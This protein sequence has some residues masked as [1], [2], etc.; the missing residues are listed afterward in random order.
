MLRAISGFAVR[1]PVLVVVLW[2]V[3]TA[4][5]FGFGVGV[6][7]RLVG[8]VDTVAGSESARATRLLEGAGDR[9]ESIAALFTGRPA[10]DPALRA[11]VDRAVAEVR[12][13]T[14]VVQVDGPLPSTATGHALLL[15]ITLE[16]DRLAG[17]GE[18]V[19]ASDVAAAVAARLHRI[20]ATVPAA[21]VVVGGGPLQAHETTAQAQKD[22]IKAELLTT[23]VVLVLLLLVFAGLIAA[24]LPLLVAVAGVGATF[25][26]LYLCSMVTDVSLYAIQTTTTLAV[27]LA[28]DYALLMVSR[29]REERRRAPDLSTAVLATATTAGR[30]VVCSGL[31]VA[32]ALAGLVVFPNPF[33]RSMGLAGATVV[34]VDA[35]AVVTLLPALLALT[36][37]HITTVRP[38]PDRGVFAA[39]ARLVQ[40]RPVIVL[41]TTAALLTLLAVPALG[42]RISQGDPRM[43]PPGSQTRQL[44]EGLATHFP[45]RVRPDGV[46]LVATATAT[47]PALLRLRDRIAALPGVSGVAVVPVSPTATV[48]DI[49]GTAD[50]VGTVR[51]V[52]APFEIAVGGSAA[53]LAD[54]RTMLTDRLPWAIAI[55]LAGTLLLLFAL[56]GSAVLPVKAV[57]TN[58]L[59]LAAALGVVVWVFQNGH[60][61]AVLDDQGLGYVHLT[62]PVLAGAIAFGLA[63]DYEVF[64]LARIRE[65]WLTDAEPHTCVAHG[66]QRTGGI[67]T[68]AALILGVVFGG[69]LVGG[70]TPIKAVGLGLLVAVVLDAT[71]VRMLLVPATMT[72]LGR[73][74]WWLPG[75][76]HTLHRRIAITET[77][78]T[79]PPA[80][81][82][83]TAGQ[84]A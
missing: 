24:G 72:L 33:L 60:L 81:Q 11:A 64:L 8:D 28:V 83:R 54:Y 30:T 74:N 46:E 48:L 40:R 25:G 51:A 41:L 50:L 5:G 14:G 16:P 52:D 27:G 73:H 17:V 2:T 84:P 26:V 58:T 1:R 71:I 67:I 66:M 57:L 18:P 49:D 12:L 53:Q 20:A 65:H 10:D 13:M 59:S 45:E 6:F 56:T 47:D 36:G 82:D 7:D 70:F 4:V 78:A 77:T 34:A 15:R 44:W 21:Q 76:L 62:V 9:P 61:A 63:M 68:A 32:V 42:M 38:R 19:D 39:V 35:L 31:T 75:P 55:V 3:V 43:M 23:P 69:F 29:F 80:T 79:A 37:R 22:V